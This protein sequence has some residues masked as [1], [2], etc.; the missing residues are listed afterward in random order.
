MRSPM[1]VRPYLDLLR[2]NPAFARLYGAQ[3][4]SFAGD[5][6]ATV[7]LL[8]LALELTGS[9]PLPRSCWWCRPAASPSPRPSPACWPIGSIAGG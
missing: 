2:R 7:A 5:W 1:R 3:L 9:P 8:G 6:F 4:M